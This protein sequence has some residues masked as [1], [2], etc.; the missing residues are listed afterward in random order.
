MRSTSALGVL[1]LVDGLVAD[2]GG[3]A[4]VAPVL[5]HLGVQE[6]LVDG[7]ELSRQHLVQ[8]VDDLFEPFM[9]RPLDPR[10]TAPARLR[11]RT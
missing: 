7:D 2:L 10:A 8:Q 4:Q 5:A 3:D 6:V 11:P 1:H 9:T